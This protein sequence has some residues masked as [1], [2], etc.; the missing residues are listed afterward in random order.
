MP[1][2]PLP[3]ILPNCHSSCRWDAHIFSDAPW[4]GEDGIWES[5]SPGHWLWRTDL[6][7]LQLPSNAHLGW[8]LWSRC[9]DIYPD[10]QVAIQAGTS[11]LPVEIC[12]KDW[13]H[14]NPQCCSSHQPGPLLSAILRGHRP[15][16][17]APLTPMQ[18]RRKPYP[19]IVK[20]Q[21]LILNGYNSQPKL[22]R[23]VVEIQFK[24]EKEWKKFPQSWK[25][26]LET[27]GF[28]KIHW[29]SGTD[30]LPIYEEKLSRISPTGTG[31]PLSSPSELAQTQ[32]EEGPTTLILA[33]TQSYR[34][35]FW[36][37][38]TMG[39]LLWPQTQLFLSGSNK[40]DRLNASKKDLKSWLGRIFELTK[41]W[42]IKWW[43]VETIIFRFKFDQ[44]LNDSQYH[45]VDKISHYAPRD[46]QYICMSA[47]AKVDPDQL[48][49]RGPLLHFGW[50][51]FLD[52]INI[53]ICKWISGQG[54]LSLQT[55]LRRRFSWS[56][57]FQQPIWSG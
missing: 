33:P 22:T 55:R 46:H 29:T 43:N 35:D 32:T 21:L 30:L 12:H 39:R 52:N 44:L 50:W 54:R 26:Q 1:T 57:L 24:D 53:F 37:H 20:S 25:D 34:T 19:A 40:N 17:P 9:L 49:E 45:F 42:K 36:C 15:S 13:K 38:Q 28:D 41:L 3:N 48:E 31:K 51:S 10:F 56:W 8:S 7:S 5:I 14:S 2:S 11:H 4:Y 27:P 18:G 6:Q 47:T 16:V 23:C